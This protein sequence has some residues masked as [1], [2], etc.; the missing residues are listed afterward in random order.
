MKSKAPEQFQG[1][2]ITSLAKLKSVAAGNDSMAACGVCGRFSCIC[3]AASSSDFVTPFSGDQN[4]T[5]PK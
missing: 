1:K 4:G 2:Q 3:Y 5:D